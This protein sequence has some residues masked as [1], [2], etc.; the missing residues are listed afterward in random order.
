MKITEPKTPFV[1]Y[2]AELDIV[3]NMEDIPKFNL[4]RRNSN[5]P[6]PSYST[7]NDSVSNTSNTDGQQ[8]M[9]PEAQASELPPAAGP[10]E[11]R[12]SFEAKQRSN[13]TGS[14]SSSRSTSFR[15]PDEEHARL[16]RKSAEGGGA[17]DDEDDELDPEAQAKREAFLL[18]RG[19]HYSNEAEAMKRAQ[20][21]MAKEDEDAEGSQGSMEV[22]DDAE[23]EAVRTGRSKVPPVP[24][25]PNNINGVGK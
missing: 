22:D 21:L 7:F 9:S 25:L 11:R 5:P 1:R 24:P 3:E 4:D 6:T 10:E 14:R 2:N 13:S 17:F 8:T 16:R 18:A 20:E 15:F 12:A 19:R 23:E